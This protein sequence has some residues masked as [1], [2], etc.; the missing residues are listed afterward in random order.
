VKFGSREECL[1]KTQRSETRRFHEQRDAVCIVEIDA[2][3]SINPVPIGGCDA[4]AEV[5][6]CI[7]KMLALDGCSFNWEVGSPI[8][9]LSID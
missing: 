4:I 7:R 1:F 2:C 5:G 8:N 6:R 9:D 3:K